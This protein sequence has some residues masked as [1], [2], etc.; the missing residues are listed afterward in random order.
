MGLDFFASGD[1]DALGFQSP[2]LKLPGVLGQG[3]QKQTPRQGFETIWEAIPGVTGRGVKREQEGNHL[4]PRSLTGHLGDRGKHSSALSAPGARRWRTYPPS[5]IHHWLKLL[6]GHWHLGTSGL[7]PG[8]CTLLQLE[9]SSGRVS[10][11]L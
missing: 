3:P 7:H 9:K 5:A 1:V 6:P 10:G 4:P 8:P 2:E 11:A